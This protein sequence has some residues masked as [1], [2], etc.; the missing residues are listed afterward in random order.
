MPGEPVFERGLIDMRAGH[1]AYHR[2]G[3]GAVAILLLHGLGDN[4][5][6]WSRTA[7]A[8]ANDF[9][10][11]M[12]DARGH[13]GSS[14]PDA[15]G[16]YD[17]A[18]DILEVLDRLELDRVIVLG[19]SVGA[20]AACQFAAAYHARVAALLLE[21]PTF[22][23]EVASPSE[24]MI[25]AFT[26][27]IQRYGEMSLER[28]MAA[29]CAQHPSW[30]GCEFESWAHGKQQ[31]HPAILQQ[32][33]FPAWHELLAQTEIPTLMMQGEPGSDSAMS[34]R[35][36]DDITSTY[37]H[38]QSVVIQ[39]AGH[40]IRRENFAAFLDAVLDFIRNLHEIVVRP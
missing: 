18:Q 38:V 21:D 29:G 16:T 27:Q 22:R 31:V 14:M 2:A 3:T 37:P 4:G 26:K 39:G 32:Y 30:D 7:Q 20:I 19:H 15:D 25:A 8:L 33:R 11:I 1:M 17:P 13:G 34:P 9:T 24:Q 6:C 35:R 10:V 23:D 36:A 12:L 28:V 5:L 40:N